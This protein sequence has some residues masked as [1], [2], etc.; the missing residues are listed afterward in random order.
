M[1]KTINSTVRTGTYYPD[2]R[3][4]LLDHRTIIT[5]NITINHPYMAIGTALTKARECLDRQH[6]TKA[7]TFLQE[8]EEHSHNLYDAAGRWQRTAEEL[9]TVGF[10]AILTISSAVTKLLG[11]VE[12]PASL[13]EEHGNPGRKPAP[14]PP[15]P[16]PKTPS[17]AK[18]RKEG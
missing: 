15:A 1:A 12:H 10:D 16:A 14:R 2:H 13:T 8:A 7:L 17:R 11:A 3:F 5:R 18:S 9:A 6:L 4:Y